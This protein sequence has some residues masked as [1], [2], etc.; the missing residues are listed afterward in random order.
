MENLTRPSHPRRL[1]RHW[2]ARRP[3]PHRLTPRDRDLLGALDTYSFL[4]A[5]HLCRL[6]FGG[7][8]SLSYC[9]DRLKRLYHA[10]LVDRLFLPHVPHGSP[11]TVYTRT[12]RNPAHR[13]TWFLEHALAVM[14]FVLAIIDVCRRHAVVLDTV[15]LDRELRR[16]PVRVH[17]D[18]RRVPVIPD[19]YLRLVVGRVYELAWCVEIDRGSEPS[20]AIRRKVGRYVA[21]SAGPYQETFGT[22]AL[23]VVIVTTSGARRLAHLIAAVED[24]LE[25]LARPDQADLFRLTS[26][27]LR[28]ESPDDLLLAR[29]WWIPFQSEPVALIPEV[30]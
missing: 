20:R 26:A 27:D 21:F 22:T 30:A 16:V 24:E 4:T 29:R 12:R 11:L 9:R 15:L 13:S 23:T 18:A 14:D 7:L 25:R 6:V 3:R 2:R 8:G 1:A 10:H 17:E 19:C 5:P 28:H